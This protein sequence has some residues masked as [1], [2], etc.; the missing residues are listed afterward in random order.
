M[1]LD[2]FITF[3]ILSTQGRGERVDPKV[4]I[5]LLSKT[6]FKTLLGTHPWFLKSN[7]LEIK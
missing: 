6:K 3:T 2:T 4:V 1:P 5:E 7:I